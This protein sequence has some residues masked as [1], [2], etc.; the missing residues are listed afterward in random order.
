M[1]IVMVPGIDGSDHDHW[2]SHWERRLGEV[3][4]RIRPASWTS[5][6]L[7]DWCRALDRELDPDGRN[8]IVAHSLGCLATVAWLG[9]AST[10]DALD[11]VVLVAAPDVDD[12][13]FPRDAASTFLGVA[14]AVVPVP[15][16]MLASSN[17]PFCHPQSAVQLAWR[18]GVPVIDIGAHGHVNSASGLGDW[19]AGWQLVQAFL[20]GMGQSQRLDPRGASP[21]DAESG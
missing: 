3:A 13:R 20:A 15:A 17:D 16:L 5:P 10:S 1:R 18:W 19:N 9:N 14:T 12:P 21:C 8:L 2:Q 6:E 7:A 11:G 4:T